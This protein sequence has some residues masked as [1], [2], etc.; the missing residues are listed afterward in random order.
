LSKQTHMKYCITDLMSKIYKQTF[1]FPAWLSSSRKT[2]Q[3]QPCT[4]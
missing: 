4:G 1:L 3:A 2:C